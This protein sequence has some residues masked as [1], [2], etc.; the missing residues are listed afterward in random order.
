MLSWFPLAGFGLLSFAKIIHAHWVAP[1]LIAALPMVALAFEPDGVPL[2]RKLAK[3]GTWFAAAVAAITV[4][5]AGATAGMPWR[6]VSQ[7]PEPVGEVV[8]RTR[9]HEQLTDRLSR[10]LEARG[11]DG[12]L[13]LMGK[14]FHFT[15]LL[16]WVM[17]GREI[18]PVI[19]LEYKSYNQ[20]SVWYREGMYDGWDALYIDHK[21]HP[22]RARILSEVFDSVERLQPVDVSEDGLPVR[23]FDIY[24]CRG[25]R[26]PSLR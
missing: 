19:P 1:C 21:P 13:L 6:L 22:K 15:S 26:G 8:Q 25:F 5:I 11:G 10:E 3:A 14:S 23:R 4:L 7:M 20:F 16:L 2:D 12:E 9:G 24:Y 18:P 17:R